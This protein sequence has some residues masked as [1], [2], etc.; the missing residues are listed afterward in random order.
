MQHDYRRRVQYLLDMKREAERSV[1]IS[2][3]I[4]RNMG[5]FS[6][7]LTANSRLDNEIACQMLIHAINGA[8]LKIRQH[9]QWHYTVSSN[10][11]PFIFPDEIV[12]KVVSQGLIIERTHSITCRY[13]D[14]I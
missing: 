2:G 13:T 6:R 7:L 1:E 3:N 9:Y 10:R 5:W 8:L 14:F 4:K 11:S 12:V